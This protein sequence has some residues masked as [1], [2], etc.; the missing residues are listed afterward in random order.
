MF[1]NFCED[2]PEKVGRKNCNKWTKKGKIRL[3][4]GFINSALGV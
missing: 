2:I 4:D 1:A 3:L